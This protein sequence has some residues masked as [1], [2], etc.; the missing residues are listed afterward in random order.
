MRLDH[1]LSRETQVFS[2]FLYP[3]LSEQIWA[4]SSVGK[5]ARLISARSEVRFLSG[6][7][8]YLLTQKLIENYIGEKSKSKGRRAY[9]ECLGGW[10]R[11]RT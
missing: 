2:T 9:G 1:L 3:F 10:R 4:S 7:P 5:S 8:E 6:P 11:R